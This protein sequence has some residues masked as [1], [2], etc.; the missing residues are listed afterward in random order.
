M[1]AKFKVG[2]KVRCVE[3]DRELEGGKVYVIKSV[4]QGTY[5]MICVT[6]PHAFWYADRF[7]LVQEGSTT[8]F[9]VGQEVFLIANTSNHT[10]RLKSAVVIDVVPKYGMIRVSVGDIDCYVEED[11]LFVKE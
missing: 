9:T 10:K 8:S 6:Q 2:D 3:P 7:E 1:T 5:K 4:T 11:R